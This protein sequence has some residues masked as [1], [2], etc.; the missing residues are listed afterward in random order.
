MV[1][2][3]LERQKNALVLKEAIPE[4]ELVSVDKEKEDLFSRHLEILKTD[5]SYDGILMMED[6]IK[7]C[8]GFLDKANDVISKY[9][10]DVIQFFERALSK[11]L[12]GGWQAGGNFYSN[13]CTYFPTSIANM[14]SRNDFVEYFK[15]DIFP[16]KNE[17]WTYPM[18]TYIAWFL[19]YNNMRYWR[20]LPF[21]VQHLDFKSTLGPRSTKRQS[22]YF[23]DD[24]EVVED[25]KT[26]N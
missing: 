6:D 13:V 26:K 22:I 16:K 2:P 15:N 24:M 12:V 20:E 4:L 17:P 25:G 8:N 9:K 1:S 7:L 19:G 11:N 23:I 21:L 3:A 14:L 10:T 5:S 18:D